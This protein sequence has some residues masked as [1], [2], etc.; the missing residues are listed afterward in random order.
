MSDITAFEN[1]SIFK[2]QTTTK[3]M[4][5]IFNEPRKNRPKTWES[6]GLESL[7]AHRQFRSMLNNMTAVHSNFRMRCT[8]NRVIVRPIVWWHLSLRKWVRSKRSQRSRHLCHRFGRLKRKCC[9]QIRCPTRLDCNLVRRTSLKSAR[10]NH[11]STRR[12]A[13]RTR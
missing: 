11:R 10:R 6:R 12:L 5:Q 13:C 7:R 4:L 3:P 2:I 8:R 1:S 9:W